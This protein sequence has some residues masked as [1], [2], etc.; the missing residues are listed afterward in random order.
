M[1]PSN[2]TL[3]K[4]ILAGSLERYITNTSNADVQT[5]KIGVPIE[6]TAGNGLASPNFKGFHLKLTSGSFTNRN[7]VKT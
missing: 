2:F 1:Y 4:R 5:W 3:E 6:I 7:T